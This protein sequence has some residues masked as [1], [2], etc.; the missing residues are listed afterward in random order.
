MPI[1]VLAVVAELMT[2]VR[3]EGV[4]RSLDCPLAM[5]EPDAAAVE[6]AVVQH[7]PGV[8]VLDLTVPAKVRSAVFGAARSAGVP[9]IAFGPHVDTGAMAEARRAGAAEVL[10]RGALGHGLGPLV[11]KHLARRGRISET[12]P[13]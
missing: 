1:L 5:A 8:I 7:R 11:A 12:E 13:S 9:V 4:F 6:E 2:S 3:V 10:A